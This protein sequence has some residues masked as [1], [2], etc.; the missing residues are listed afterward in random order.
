MNAVTS[1]SQNASTR[2][3]S[4]SPSVGAPTEYVDKTRLIRRSLRCF[5]YGLIG[6]IPV[7][8]ITLAWQAIRLHRQVLRETGEACR[9]PKWWYFYWVAALAVSIVGDRLQ[10]FLGA[11]A[12]FW[13]FNGLHAVYL[14]QLA[15]T[16]TGKVWNPA[17]RYSYW[18]FGLACA[19]CFGLIALAS[20]IATELAYRSGK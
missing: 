3:R 18:G 15:S 7:V 10:G 14:F 11:L 16:R 2:D 20:I 9:L 6:A 1:H 4:F 13:G 19:G 12:A 17:R 5:I 8:G